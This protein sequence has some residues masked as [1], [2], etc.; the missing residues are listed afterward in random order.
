VKV[1]HRHVLDDSEQVQ[2]FF[3]EAALSQQ[4]DSPYV[5]KVLGSGCTEDGS[6]YLVLE[7]L[8]GHDLARELHTKGYLELDEVAR[9]IEQV[10]L[11]LAAAHELG[12]VHRDLKPQ[13]IFVTE[14]EGGRLYKVVDF[15]ACTIRNSTSSLTQGFAVGTP[16]YMA[17]EQA[18]GG[19]VDQRADVFSLG[20]IAYRALT[21]RPAFTDGDSVTTMYNVV[22]VQPVRPT[23]LRSMAEDVDLALAIALAKD[24]ASRFQSVQSLSGALSAAI[25]G[26]LT[27]ELRSTARQLLA[28]QP[29]GSELAAR[30]DAS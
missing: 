6:P 12:I 22:H 4:I 17:P 11:A 1:L 19:D 3:R 7:Y 29:W 27:D 26:R 23:E 9:M 14:G 5:A 18:L 2:R 13:N 15:G 28:L 30:Q 25:A 10:A 24:P 16:S 8:V 20:T 21:G